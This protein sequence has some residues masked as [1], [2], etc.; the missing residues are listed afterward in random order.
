M[1]ERRIEMKIAELVRRSRVGRSTIHH[2]LNIG[3][4]PPPRISGVKLHLYGEEHL[5]RL[6]QIRRMRSAGFSLTEIRDRLEKVGQSDSGDSNTGRID[7]I[8]IV[9]LRDRVLRIATQLFVSKGYH[10]VR[11]EDVAIQCRISKATLYQHFESKEDLF[12]DC[13]E[14]V[15][16]TV[17]PMEIRDRA[18]QFDVLEEAT[19][20]VRLVLKNFSVYRLL[21]TLLSNLIYSDNQR[22]ADRARREYHRMVTNMQ[23]MLRSAMDKGVFRETDTEMLAYMLWGALMGAGDRMSRDDKYSIEDTLRLHFDFIS[24]GILSRPGSKSDDDQTVPSKI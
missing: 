16:Y 17:V 6:V 21:T 24:Q 23:G 11:M 14:G 18:G 5:Q 15:R 1:S 3:L 13:I 7:E 19:E 20:R 10:A 9:S 2:Y 22:L 4:L 12:I 8:E